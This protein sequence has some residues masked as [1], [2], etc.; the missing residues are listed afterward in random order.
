MLTNESGKGGH[1]IRR[2]VLLIYPIIALFHLLFIFLQLLVVERQV[3]DFLGFM[4]APIIANFL[5]IAFLVIGIFGV[6]QYRPGYVIAVS[7]VL[8]YIQHVFMLVAAL[9]FR[10]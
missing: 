4:W 10:Y 7:V 9:L 6:Y 8:Q 2:C 3:F 1:F 5:Q